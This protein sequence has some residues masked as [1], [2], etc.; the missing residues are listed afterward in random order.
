[1]NDLHGTDVT[2]VEQKPVDTSKHVSHLH[3]IP[4]TGR[5]REAISRTLLIYA[6]GKVV[7]V[8][9]TNER[10]VSDSHFFVTS[11]NQLIVDDVSQLKVMFESIIIR[12]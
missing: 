5:R 7:S 10:N 1:M 3:P 9:R 4:P 12:F 6:G 11:G 2:S 8:E